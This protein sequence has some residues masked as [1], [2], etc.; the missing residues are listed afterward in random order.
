MK[1]LYVKRWT[2]DR[3]RHTHD[4]MVNHRGVEMEEKCLVCGKDVVFISTDEQVHWMGDGGY[5]PS[6]RSTHIEFCP[7]CGYMKVA[8]PGGW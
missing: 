1:H 5:H 3:R 4:G 8:S 2:N 7:E 6:P